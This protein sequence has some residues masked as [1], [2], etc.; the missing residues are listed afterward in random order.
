MVK[1]SLYNIR[2]SEV[3]D[4]FIA[5]IRSTDKEIQ[6]VTQHL[7]ETKEIAE[8]IGEKIQMKHV[9]GLAGLLHDMGKFTDEFK[10]YILH[11]VNNPE[12]A[13]KRGSV[14]HSTAGGRLLFEKYYINGG[15][16]KILVEVVGNA[17]L[18]H[19]GYLQDYINANLELK[20]LDRI[21][22]KELHNFEQA[23]L[24]F[25]SLVINE[26]EFD[27]YVEKALEEVTE[28]IKQIN[29]PNYSAPIMFVTKYVFSSLIDADRTSTRCFEANNSFKDSSE[30]H[31]FEEDYKKLM[32]KVHAFKDS[33][34]KITP[35]NYLRQQMSEQCDRVATKESNIY[36]LSIPTGGGKTLSSLRYALK[37][38]MTHKLKRI[39]YIV[40]FTTII[41]QNAEEIRN[42]VTESTYVLEHHSNV[43]TDDSIHVMNENLANENKLE[44]T[45][46]NWDAPIIFSTM[47]QFLDIFY[48][49]GTRNIRRLHNL[50]E[51]VIIFDEVQ[52]VPVKCISLFNS[53]VNFL[54]DNCYSSIVMCTATQ[55]A[56]KNVKHHLSIGEGSE[57]I[58]EI[59]KINEEFKRV[60]VNDRATS[61]TMST[62]DLVCFIK[63]QSRDISSQLVVLN[64]KSVVKKLY[65]SLK[66]LMPETNIYHLSTSMC[67]KHRQ[68]I[69]I[70]LRNDLEQ[71][72]PV[73]CIST[74][75]IEA[76]VDISFESVIRSL[77]GL[78]SIAQA[79]GRCN[80]HGEMDKG[81]VHV[82]DHKE[83]NLKQLTEISVGKNITKKML[84]DIKI[85]AD[86]YEGSI[87]SKS[88]M[89]YYFKKYYKEMAYDLD[90]PIP[91]LDLKMTDLLITDRS[92]WSM[93]YYNKYKRIYPLISKGSYQTAAK[94][95]KVIDNHSTPVIVPYGEG[96]EIIADINGQER[97]EELSY[98]F[99]K[100]QHYSVNVYDH[101][102]SILRLNGAI[103]EHFD[104][105]LLSLTDG[106]YN[107]EDGLDLKGEAPLTDAI[108]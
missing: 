61:G 73:V 53:A 38:A 37:H 100:A 62:N 80:R 108:F 26:Q 8:S 18:S 79:A 94:F 16:Q 11:T 7:Q 49:Q 25:Y 19:H 34:L 48:S 2:I 64:T 32:K 45:K 40:P 52:K 59:D 103:K 42:V 20:F 30:V 17:I 6:T 9:T 57:I 10:N 54:K 27:Q 23:K 65:V 74:Q 75:L 105:R 14:D 90:Y 58:D 76:G 13:P 39:I 97:I 87:L 60:E 29:Q 99:K 67:A 96:K 91:S 101:E 36:T 83:E 68:E 28:F 46:D 43:F 70:E 98:L 33:P 12:T 78:D 31:S 15:V 22:D 89:D 47:V 41:E 102:L 1:Y 85:D 81:I 4:L 93:Q 71:K 35:I 50:S 3:I 92:T 95:F 107:E 84:V 88:A 106:F 5:H 24:N 66:D 104:G 56:L 51:S 69:L 55:P 63:Q 44:L 21:K 77:A 86:A 72:K 82:I